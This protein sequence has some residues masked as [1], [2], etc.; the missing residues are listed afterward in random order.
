MAK[1]IATWGTASINGLGQGFLTEK[2]LKER[3]HGAGQG[4]TEN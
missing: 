2:W 3:A 1:G 4:I